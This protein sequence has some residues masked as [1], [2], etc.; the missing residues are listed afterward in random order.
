MESRKNLLDARSSFSPL[1][2]IPAQTKEA[3]KTMAVGRS[4]R[5][6]GICI[7]KLLTYKSRKK[8]E[9]YKK[10]ELHFYPLR[11]VISIIEQF[12]V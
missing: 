9:A 3:N 5:K 2:T 10:G 6:T 7:S 8:R 12:A 4:K 1:E 11:F